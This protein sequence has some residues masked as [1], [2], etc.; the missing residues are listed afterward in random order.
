[1]TDLVKDIVGTSEFTEILIVR[2]G[3][4]VRV[5]NTPRP[6]PELSPIGRGQ[7][8]AVGE[9]LAQEPITAL[10]S[11]NMR[12]AAETASPAARLLD[13]PV[14]VDADLAEFELGADYYIPLE[15]MR[16]EQDPRLDRFRAWIDSPE[17]PAILDGYQVRVVNALER[18]V[19]D[20]LG[21]VVAVFAHG[22]VVNA[23][24]RKA[25]DHPGRSVVEAVYASMTRIQIT[26]DLRW[27]LRSFNEIQHLRQSR[28]YAGSPSATAR[29][30][31]M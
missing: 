10:Y 11:S 4:P 6:D 9:W 13:L 30:R 25:L 29:T 21:G 3:L 8:Q 5:E 2:H 24:A 18:I 26:A 20:N 17:A 31:S 14:H 22:G 16:A 19:A 7:A 15:E 27:K 1:M 23:A 28:P 12:R